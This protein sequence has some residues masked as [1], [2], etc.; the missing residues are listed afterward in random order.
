MVGEVGFFFDVILSTALALSFELERSLW[1]PFSPGALLLFAFLWRGRAALLV[2]DLACSSS[3][4]EMAVA[5]FLFF[6]LPL[7]AEPFVAFVGLTGD[8]AQVTSK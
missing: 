6:P 4:E 1:S 3:S 7:V 8:L 5:F 2:E